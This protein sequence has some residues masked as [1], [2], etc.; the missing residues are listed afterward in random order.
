MYLQAIEKD[1]LTLSSPNNIWPAYIPP[2]E[3]EIF[4]SWFMRLCKSHDIKS[5]SFAK[6]YFENESI[7]N[8]D[9]DLYP[10]ENLLS[11]IVNYTPMTI[12]NVREMFLQSYKDIVY[13]IT[14]TGSINTLGIFHRKRKKFGMLF[15]P[16]CLSEEN[17]YY[18]KNWRL[19]TSIVCTKCNLYLQDRCPNCQFPVCFHRLETGYKSSI[20]NFSLDICFNCKKSICQKFTSATN[21]SLLYQNYIDKTISIGF[22]DKTAYSFTYFQIL[23][24][25]QTRMYTQSK[26]WSRIKN[27]IENEFSL[28]SQTK[29]FFSDFNNLNQRKESLYISYYLLEFWP[30]RF[31]DF[32]I[33]YG[34]NYSEF[35]KD[36]HLPF[37]FTDVLK[38]N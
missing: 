27:A 21:E 37:W 28:N 22:N 8:R 12:D 7:W 34:L 5:H 17:K 6:F 16:G 25:F 13:N 18:R 15:C 31:I 38:Q 26:S 10:S 36:K 14:S 11:Q 29:F 35:T 20:L 2:F 30:T 1:K 4:S 32:Y 33:K 3:N 23:Y 9:I 19:V 24:L